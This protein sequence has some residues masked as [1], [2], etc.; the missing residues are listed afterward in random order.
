M[1]AFALRLIRASL[2]AGPILWLASCAS[3]PPQDAATVLARASQAMGAGRVNT[4]RYSAEEVQGLEGKILLGSAAT[5]QQFISNANK[6]AI[7]SN[8][9]RSR[10]SILS[11]QLHCR[12]PILA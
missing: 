10:A 3:A 4:L 7:R 12:R 5:K 8:S 1:K 11:L 9:E 2:V 6:C